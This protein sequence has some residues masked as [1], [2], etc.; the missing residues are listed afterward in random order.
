MQGKKC[1]TSIGERVRCI[2]KELGYTQ[3]EFASLLNCDQTA[4]SRL[5]R[6][7]RTLDVDAMYILHKQCSVDMNWLVSGEGE[8]MLGEGE[9]EYVAEVEL[10]GLKEW[11]V[12]QSEN[13]PGIWG[14]FSVQFKKKF[15]EYRKW[16]KKRDAAATESV[17]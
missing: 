16:L 14:W 6:G 9:Y 15:P 13:E 11:L 7:K 8:L 12:E 2:R 5:E 1:E 3:G 10:E 4:V 17:A